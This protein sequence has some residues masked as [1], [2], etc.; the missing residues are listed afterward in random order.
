[1]STEDTKKNAYPR[2]PAIASIVLGVLAV[3]PDSGKLSR[4]PPRVGFDRPRS[5][6]TLEGSAP[7]SRLGQPLPVLPSWDTSGA[8][9]NLH[10]SRSWLPPTLGRRR[11]VDPARERFL[12]P[13][14]MLPAMLEHD[15]RARGWFGRAGGA[16]ARREHP[17]VPGQAIQMQ[18][19]RV[20]RSRRAHAGARAQSGLAPFSAI[21]VGAEEPLD[22]TR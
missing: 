9:R 2:V 16:A 10:G 22:G 11:R 12:R 17:R 13:D 5:V 6:G 19:H 21:K 20:F 4:C 1:V 14:P 8:S 15:R 7:P 3:Q 18:M